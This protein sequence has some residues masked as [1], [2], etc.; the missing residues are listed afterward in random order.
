MMQEM[1]TQLESVE[2]NV[3]LAD[4]RFALPAA[5]QALLDEG[6][7]EEPSEGSATDATAA[8]STLEEPVAAAGGISP[9]Q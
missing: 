9:R 8:P 4:D 1:V 2:H 6:A 3:E 7:A 5:V